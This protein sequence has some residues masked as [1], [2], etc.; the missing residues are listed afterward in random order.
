MMLLAYHAITVRDHFSY[1][2]ISIISWKIQYRVMKYITLNYLKNADV[3]R[4]SLSAHKMKERMKSGT[5][6][7]RD[8]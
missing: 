5:N 3:S 1:K 6:E 2:I 7:K 8:E 4:C